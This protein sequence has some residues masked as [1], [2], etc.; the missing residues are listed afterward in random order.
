MRL[1][2]ILFFLLALVPGYAQ[3]MPFLQ[4]S[5]SAETDRIFNPLEYRTTITTSFEMQLDAATERAQLV[6]NPALEQLSASLRI[7][8]FAYNDWER[9]SEHQVPAPEVGVFMFDTTNWSPGTY[10]IQIDQ[11]DGA[12]LMMLKFD[13]G[14]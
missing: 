1:L 10:I 7:T 3:R 12:P 4:P 11:S 14:L 2:L 5:D 6:W 13:W 8:L 9:L